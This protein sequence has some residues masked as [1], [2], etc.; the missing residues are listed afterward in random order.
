MWCWEVRRPQSRAR[1][2]SSAASDWYKRQQI[3]RVQG[4]HCNEK[5][6]GCIGDAEQIFCQGLLRV[7]QKWFWHPR[8]FC[9]EL[10]YWL[11]DKLVHKP[12]IYRVRG[13]LCNAKSEGWI[14]DA[15]KMFCQSLSSLH[16][17]YRRHPL[18]GVGIYTHWL[19]CNSVGNLP[20]LPIQGFL[21]NEY[22]AVR[23]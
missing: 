11:K 20:Q 19:V 21:I 8:F 23:H 14:K 2:S 7:Y 3:Y 12:Q 4:P 13:P 1:V 9:S 10:T 18:I 6:E 17:W 15:E 5:S 16:W 22:S